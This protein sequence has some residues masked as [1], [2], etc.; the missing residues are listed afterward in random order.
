MKKILQ[1][2]FSA[3][4][5]LGASSAQAQLSA[6][7]ILVGGGA[8]FSSNHPNDQNP[9][10]DTKSS[11][12]FFSPRAGYFLADNFVVGLEGSYSGDKDVR[13]QQIYLPNGGRAD[14]TITSTSTAT[15]I[16]P[17]ARYYKPLGEKA[18]IFGHLGFGFGGRKLTTDYEGPN[19][20]EDPKDVKFGSMS[21]SITPGFAY[22]PTKRF[23]LEIMTNAISA[24]YY[25]QR[26][27]DLPEGAKEEDYTTSNFNAQADLRS[28]FT[29]GNIQIGAT[30]YLGG[31]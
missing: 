5:L 14:F 29:L 30:F 24:G 1:A 26:Q 15:T 23:G 9:T 10:L 6:G 20:P 16:G 21:A 13:T 27:K 2:A 31:E 19:A 7:H 11:R 3:V 28:L 8:G 12:G 17:F 25:R 18:A 4:F 22:F